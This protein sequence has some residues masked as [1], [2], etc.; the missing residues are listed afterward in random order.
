MSEYTVT[1]TAAADALFAD[2]ELQLLLDNDDGAAQ[3]LSQS[4]AVL[5]PQHGFGDGDDSGEG[6]DDAWALA[7]P[8][9]RRCAARAFNKLGDIMNCSE[10]AYAAADVASV[11]L[12]SVGALPIQV[13]I[14]A[15]I[16]FS[17]ALVDDNP[18]D[19]N[20]CNVLLHTHRPFYRCTH[21]WRWR[22]W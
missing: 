14:V 20:P 7:A 6:V 4:A 3:L 9:V 1:D 22:V 10:G 17:Y 11:Y 2:A 5:A 13:C 16:E 19:T 18:H 12:A 8:R 21:S 15:E